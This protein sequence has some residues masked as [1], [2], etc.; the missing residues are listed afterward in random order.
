MSLFVLARPKGNLRKDGPVLN[1]TQGVHRINKDV[2][3]VTMGHLLRMEVPYSIRNVGHQVDC[4][5]KG[6]RLEP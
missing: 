6:E 4:G 2:F 1:K 3:E 5:W